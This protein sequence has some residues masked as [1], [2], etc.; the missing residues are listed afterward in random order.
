MFKLMMGNNF[1]SELI[2]FIIEKNKEYSDVKISEVFGSIRS[3][4]VIKTARPD[5]RVPEISLDKFSEICNKL[6]SNGIIINYTSNTPIV[7]HKNIDEK[8]YEEFLH[9]L[10]DFGVRRITVAHPL[11]IKIIGKIFPKMKVELSTIYRIQHPRQL[12]DIKG[13]NK[14]FN[15][16]CVDIIRN[17]D[18]Y[19]LKDMKKYCDELDIEMELLAN[20]FCI[21]NCVVRD[22][23]YHAHVMNKTVEDTRHFNHWP[24][25]YCIT[26][27]ERE[28]IEWIYATFILPQH[29]KLYYEEF[30]IE[31]FKVTGRTAPTPYAKWVAETYLS[32]EHNGN[33]LELWQDVKNISRVASGKDDFIRMRYSIDSDKIDENFI[34]WYFS[35]K[36]SWSE[37]KKHI[38]E[39]FEKA[40]R[41]F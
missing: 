7:D 24:M 39:Y 15:K 14:S 34:K 26:K 9:K 2:D 13:F 12:Y 8:N 10:Y 36:V 40:F 20:E 1:D 27:R 22:Q 25:G 37:E 41:E 29:M 21:Y 3:L 18:Y 23:C 33:L 19:H 28:P 32:Q 6:K 16:I 17:R 35:K 38:E 31:N 4:N 11:I 5:F 30:G